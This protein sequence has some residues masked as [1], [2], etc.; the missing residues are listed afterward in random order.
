MVTEKCLTTPVFIDFLKRLLH[1]T[2]RPVFLVVDGHPVHRSKRVREFVADTKGRLQLFF[3]PAYS[4]E[5]NPDEL[6]WNHVKSHKIGRTVVETK[7]QREKLAR[8]VMFSLQKQ[9][10]LVQRFFH[11]TSPPITFILE[12]QRREGAVQSQRG[13]GAFVVLVGTKRDKSVQV[14]GSSSGWDR[15]ARQLF[16]QAQLMPLGHHE[17]RFRCTSTWPAT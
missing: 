12:D 7:A 4:P 1:G 5:L 8:S 3:L 6:V 17:S 13:A 2:E 9:A 16:S 15:F 11:E 10:R 14:C